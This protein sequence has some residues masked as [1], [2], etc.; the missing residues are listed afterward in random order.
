[1]EVEAVDEGTI[2][3]LLVA[4]G[5]EHVPVDQPI[6]LLMT[7]DEDEARASSFETR[8]MAA[9]QDEELSPHSDGLAPHAE[10]SAAA[11]VSKGEAAGYSPSPPPLPNGERG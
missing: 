10:E 3:K 6:A 4:E 11:P 7:E 8:P 9:P 5:T 1:M 2:G